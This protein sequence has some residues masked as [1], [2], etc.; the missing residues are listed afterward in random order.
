MDLWGK[1]SV[2]FCRLSRSSS[3]APTSRPSMNRQAAG[4][5]LS[6]DRPSTDP[7]GA[8]VLEPFTG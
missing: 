8:D 1:A 5:W 2:R 7:A 6:A 4:S 3:T